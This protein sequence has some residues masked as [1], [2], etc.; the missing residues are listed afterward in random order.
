[1]NNRAIFAERLKQLRELEL[2]KTQKEFAEL[3]ES[4]P[5]TISAYEN[6]TKNPSLDIVQNIAKKCSVSIDWLCGLTDNMTSNEPPKKFSDVINML[7]TMEDSSYLRI[8][9]H[10]TSNFEGST[11]CIIFDNLEMEHFIVEWEKMKDLYE[12]QLIDI[13]VYDLWKEKELIKYNSEIAIPFPSL[14][15]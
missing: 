14:D 7:F 4:T 8:V 2:E 11:A 15:E 13:D 3:V 9:P 12:K 10:I 5:A 6:A 1:M